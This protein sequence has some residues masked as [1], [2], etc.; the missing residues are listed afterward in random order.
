MASRLKLDDGSGAPHYRKVDKAAL[1]QAK[2]E[3]TAVLHRT[4]KAEIISDHELKHIDP[5]EKAA[6]RFFA[7]PKVYKVHVILSLVRSCHSV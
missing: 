6:G 3:I 5:S 7:L 2:E 1:D 4:H